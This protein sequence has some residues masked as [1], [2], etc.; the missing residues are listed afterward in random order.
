MARRALHDPAA[1]PAYRE[2]HGTLTYPEGTA[3]ADVLI[4]GE[5]GG[6]FA[7]RVF[8]GL[9]LGGLYTLFQNDNLFGAWPGTPDYQPKLA[10][11]RGDPCGCDAGVPRG[12]LHHWTA[13]VR[14]SSSRAASSPGWSSCR[15]STSLDRIC[16]MRSTPARSL[17]TMMS[18]SELWAKLH[19]ADGRGRSRGIRPYN[20]AQDDAHHPRR[21]AGSGPSEEYGEGREQNRGVSRTD[22]DLPMS[23]RDLR[24]RRACR[25][26][27]VV[28]PSVQAGTGSADRTR[29]RT[30]PPPFS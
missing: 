26:S 20:A 10:Q 22:R 6:S 13:C 4:A 7:S 24:L 2:E 28:L 21:T 8:F 5:H 27:D 23:R 29:L 9:G 11:G 19:P 18:P 17:S 16:Q 3:C 14:R 25:P 1:A 15:L 12:W 30:S